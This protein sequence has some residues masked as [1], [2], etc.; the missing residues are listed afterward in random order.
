MKRCSKCHVEK[1][2]NAF[3][4]RKDRTSGLQSR[5][6][7]CL[8]A[9]FS[10]YHAKNSKAL[11]EKRAAYVKANAAEIKVKQ[12][13]YH[14]ANRDALNA[15]YR[16][17]AKR[18]PQKRQAI[19]VARRAKKLQAYPAWANKTYIAL[20]YEQARLESARLGI[21]VHVDHIVPLVS[22][23]VC[24][25]HCEHNLQLLSASANLTKSN[26]LWP[27]MP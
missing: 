2:K 22:S 24:G 18:N 7:E 17:Y 19:R 23:L 9:A 12:A 11:C 3:N 15:Y 26:R 1:P 21:E 6:R 20:F 27:D 16:E 4:I 10:T 25:L 8:G 14:E 13:A 5:C